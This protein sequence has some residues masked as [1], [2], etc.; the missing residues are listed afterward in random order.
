MCE[1]FYDVSE[2]QVETLAIVPK[3]KADTWLKR[4]GEPE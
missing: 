1:F 2:N 3:S 4:F